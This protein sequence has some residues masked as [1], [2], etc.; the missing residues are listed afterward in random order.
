MSNHVQSIY[1]DADGVMWFGAPRRGVSRYDGKGF[2]NFTTTDGLTDSDVPAI[3]RGADG[4]LWVGTGKGGVCRYDEK[5][6]VN[7]TTTDGLADNWINT[8]YRDADGGLWFGTMDGGVCR[9]DGKESVSFNLRGELPDV[10]VNAIHQ[11]TDG[12]LWFG[13]GGGVSRYDG[14]R[15]VNFTTKDGLA[16][17]LVIS[18]HQAADGGLWFGTWGGISRYDGRGFVNYTTY[19][20]LPFN[21]VT[22]IY[23][24]VDGAMWF[25]T[26]SYGDGGGVC[27]YDGKKFVTFTTKDG[28]A[29]NNVWAIHRD[30]D[31]VLW[32]G[33]MGGISQYDGDKFVTFTK[34]DGLAHNWVRVIYPDPDRDGVLWF[35]TRGGG[36]SQYDGVAWT[37]LDTRDGLA[38]NSVSSICQ[39]SDG[40]L[41]FGTTGGLTRYR[42]ETTPPR[43]RIVAVTTDQRY[44]DL[45][46]LVPV[47]TG[48]RVTFEYS[49]IDFKTHPPKRLYRYQLSGYDTDWSK[50]TR[51]TQRDYG[52]LPVGAYT[53]QVQ[54][55]DRDGNYSAPASV[56]LTVVPLP[57]EEELRK[58][59]EELEAAYRNLAVKNVQLE[60]AKAAAEEAQR[61]AEA[62]NR[63]K[64][65]FIANM[66]HELRTPL[67]PIINLPKILLRDKNLPPNYR[68]SIETI[69]KSG[70]HLLALIDDVLDLSKIEAGR[71][72]LQKVNFDLKALVGD[73]SVMFQFRCGQKGLAWHVEW[74]IGNEGNKEWEGWEGKE[75]F[76]K[77]RRI[78]P[79]EINPAEWKDGSRAGPIH[80]TEHGSPVQKTVRRE[81]KE[82]FDKLR[83][84]EPVEINPAEWKDGR[85]QSFNLLPFQ[86]S[87][88]LLVH[89]DEGKLR[90]VLINLL[91]NAVKFTESG[92]VILRIRESADGRDSSM[93]GKEGDFTFHVSRFTFEVID[94][95]VGISPEEQAKIFESFYQGEAGAVMGGTGLGLTIA[96][97]LVEL[98]GGQLSFES[99]VGTGSRFYF[100][101]PLSPATGEISSP[102]VDVGKSVVRLAEGYHV[103]ALVVDDVKENR[104]VLGKL[105]SEIGVDVRLAENGRQAVE[106][107]R[108]SLP[109]IVFMD[110][111]MKP[112]GGVEAARQ[113]WRELGREALK[114]V[115]VS[116]SVLEQEQKKY[117]SH[118][119]DAF[120][121]KPLY[122]RDI[123]ACLANLLRV[124]YEYADAEGGDAT[125]LELSKITLPEALFRRLKEAGEL[126]STTELKEY[127]NE[128]EQL[129]PDGHRLAEHLRRFVDQYDIDTFLNRLGEINHE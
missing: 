126:Q 73:L 84:I 40:Y 61:A 94:T 79:V 68:G 32:F 12:A 70:T 72:E 49:S 93:E 116:A 86:P 82:G 111:R 42:R 9:Y 34:A 90:Q 54:A 76:D 112:M 104:D 124:E 125:P 44:T 53:F 118:G 102:S 21:W 27:R 56:T 6:F 64:S 105:L 69:E 66:S 127:L 17:N 45:D 50:P 51:E 19:H 37:S 3:Y 108:A 67:N 129:G 8:I 91:G 113:M 55:I 98:M 31:G 2:V 60:A 59:R 120:L 25:A 103:K 18:I 65:I 87:S 92:K 28:L 20:G 38:G 10:G 77:L 29:H 58:T 16:H 74:G 63:A 39:D 48:T 110:I 13:T 101:V 78:E 83:R 30:A 24:D 80:R 4:G 88:P 71:M 75:G 26:G 95:G 36:I 57:H 123:Y 35:G 97:T 99:E 122:E 81:E 106:L 1:R 41:W 7:F 114:I 47:T 107:V 43:A 89:G 52:N 11:D 119:F 109:D 14:D 22:A 115:A 33:T 100:T 117:L 128:V 5:A 85:R 23:Q 15:F 96:K 121:R 62:A 46:A